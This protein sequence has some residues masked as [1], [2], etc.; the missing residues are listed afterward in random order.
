MR[1][2]HVQG[3]REGGRRSSMPRSVHPSAR[4]FGF[5]TAK[6]EEPGEKRQRAR[7]SAR[8]A[9]PAQRSSQ[10]DKAAERWLGGGGRLGG[11]RLDR[12][13]GGRPPPPPKIRQLPG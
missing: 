1:S 13:P 4:I 5:G 11:P 8:G 9:R 2:S 12:R 3:G 7:Q 10:A 6:R